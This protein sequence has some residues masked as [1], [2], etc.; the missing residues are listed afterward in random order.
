MTPPAESARSLLHD[1][2]L[3]RRHEAVS[4]LATLLSTLDELMHAPDDADLRHVAQHQ[5]HQFVGVLGVFGFSDL[6]SRMARIDIELSDP[7]VDL[8]VV[9]ASAREIMADLP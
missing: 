1:M 8:A 5:A 3:A 7:T 6:K 9:V 4:D 2:W